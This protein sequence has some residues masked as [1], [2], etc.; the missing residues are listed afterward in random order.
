MRLVDGINYIG[1]KRS[2][3]MYT[4]ILP[5]DYKQYDKVTCKKMAEQILE[6]YQEPQNIINLCTEKE[7]KFLQLLTEKEDFYWELEEDL[8][9]KYYWEIRLLV[10]KL[11]ICLYDDNSI[12]IHDDLIAV[13]KRIFKVIDWQE[14][15]KID[16]INEFLVSFCKI[17]GIVPAS[18]LADE[19]SRIFNMEYEEI[20][21][22]LINDGVF[23]YYVTFRKTNNEQKSLFDEDDQFVCIYRNYLYLEDKIYQTIRNNKFSGWSMLDMKEYHNIFYYDFDIDNPKIARVVDRIKKG[24]LSTYFIIRDNMLETVLLN[25]SRLKVKSIVENILDLSDVEKDD[26][27]KAMDEAMDDMP[28]GA[29]SGFTAKEMRE[30][31][32]KEKLLKEENLKKNFKQ[33]NAHLSKKDSELFDKI[34]TALLEY[35]NTKYRMLPFIKIYQNP[36][37]NPDEIAP[38]IEK[39]WNNK[40]V[41]ITEFCLKNPSKL[42]SNEL[43]LASQF[44]NSIRSNFYL[45]R[46]YQ[47]YTAYID[48]VDD[49]VYMVKSVGS[50]TDKY[51]DKNNLPYMV[52][53]T[54]IPFNGFIVFDKLESLVNDS[55]IFAFEYKRI[56]EILNKADFIYKL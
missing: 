8:Y 24:L 49:K 47:D 12:E 21:K 37:L 18:R 41:V 48:T 20:T 23:L 54:L 52:E 33:K 25:S 46:F 13:T 38:I 15:Q 11:I 4:R 6:F 34:F 43:K 16:R 10:E 19:A 30:L 44:K 17:F 53:T 2:Y 29:L 55:S 45:S 31:K 35:T 40:N 3:S 22:H 9:K 27:M 7:L 26:F 50:N 56:D 1:K 14:K 39:F 28:S 51:I 32:Q 42:N 36:Y 5:K